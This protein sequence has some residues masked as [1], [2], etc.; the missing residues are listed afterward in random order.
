MGQC[1]AGIARVRA[2]R[3]PAL[4]APATRPH[5]AYTHARH[6]GALTLQ[7]DHAV[8]DAPVLHGRPLNARALAGGPLGLRAVGVG[9]GL[10]TGQ[11][12]GMDVTE[13]SAGR[14]IKKK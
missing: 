5:R 6:V 4:S 14:H 11:C 8:H 1:I 3:T 10:V 9:V 12:G 13:P 2:L 7:P